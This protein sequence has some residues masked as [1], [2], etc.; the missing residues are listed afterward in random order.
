M[1]GDHSHRAP[2]QRL[3]TALVLTAS[4]LVVEVVG[5]LLAGSLALLADAAHM[6]MDVGALVLSFAAASLAERRSTTRHTFGLHRAE[7]LAAFVNAEVLLLA[8]GY[9]LF[10]AYTR[11][12]Q[13][14]PV[15][16]AL[17]AGVSLVGL[18]ANLAALFVLGAG[19]DESINV[20]AAYLEV[21]TDTLASVGVLLAALLM[22][23]TGWYW[24]D[25]L[26]TAAIAIFI[27]PRT[28]TL[29]KESVH[30]LLEGSPLNLDLERLR[31]EILAV[32]GVEGLHDLHVWSLTSGLPSASLHVLASA[33][34]S[35]REVL[36]AVQA[37]LS[38][39]AGVEHATIQIEWGAG[40]HC[41]RTEHEF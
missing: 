37:V 33:D 31:A 36:R 41:E 10:Q 32:A 6:L 7:V 20:R 25:P 35:H 2:K 26:V 13:P 21:F 22:T 11:F 12:Q 19:R 3:L 5:G 27:V 15:E 16:T 29:L 4:I 17:M 38:E 8:S 34:S 39:R 9:L 18:V 24:L 28:I 30:V 14:P 23:P 40:A 1:H